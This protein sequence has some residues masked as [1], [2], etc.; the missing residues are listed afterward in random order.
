MGGGTTTQRGAIM[1]DGAKE[2]DAFNY[3]LSSD[4]TYIECALGE[5]IMRWG[6]FWRSLRFS[7]DKN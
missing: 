6:I 3:C 2:M 7:L 4:R 5:L 1:Q